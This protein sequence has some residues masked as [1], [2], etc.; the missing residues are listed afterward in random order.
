MSGEWRS[1]VKERRRVDGRR[2][3]EKRRREDTQSGE[4]EAAQVVVS[5]RHTLKAS[6]R[7]VHLLA[8]PSP[9]LVA[10]DSCSVEQTTTAAAATALDCGTRQTDGRRRT[11]GDCSFV[12][13]SSVTGTACQRSECEG[14]K[15]GG[16]RVELLVRVAR[17][18]RQQQQEQESGGGGRQASEATAAPLGPLDAAREDA[19]DEGSR[20]PIGARVH[21]K[22]T[23]YDCLSGFT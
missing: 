9:C 10:A 5:S 7:L 14:A 17:W 2:G 4:R 22:S 21:D 16:S 11:G 23:S 8:Q 15:G 3:R 19:G 18:K 20:W 13:G 1:R 12:G 6:R